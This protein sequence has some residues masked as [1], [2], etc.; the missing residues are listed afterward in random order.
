MVSF[1]IVMVK[2]GSVWVLPSNVWS[3]S[4]KVKLYKAVVKWCTVVR[5]RGWVR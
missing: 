5:S 2:S 3:G 1:G 4:T